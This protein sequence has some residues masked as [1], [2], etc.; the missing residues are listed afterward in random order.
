M[1]NLTSVGF[2]GKLPRTGD[3]VQRRLPP[4]FVDKWDG[5]FEAAVAGVRV[6]LAQEWPA[7]YRESPIWRFVLAPG[8]CT[9]SGWAGVFGPSVDRVGRWF[10]M[11][12]AAPLNADPAAAVRLLRSGDNWFNE[13]E[14]AYW[15]G[16]SSE[17]SSLEVFDARV[18]ALSG[19]LDHI[20]HNVSVNPKEVDW[21]AGTH[22][23][24]PIPVAGAVSVWMSDVWSQLLLAQ[25]PWCQWWTIGGSKRV[26][27]TTLLTQGLPQSSAY[28]GFLK[29]DC[30]SSVWQ[31]PPGIVFPDPFLAA[32]SRPLTAFASTGSCVDG[33]GLS[34]PEWADRVA[35]EGDWSTKQPS[36]GHLGAL[37]SGLTCGASADPDLI[38]LAACQPEE[39]RHV[40]VFHK[41]SL[42]LILVAADDGEILGDRHGTDQVGAI[43]EALSGTS[44]LEAA[45]LRKD[46][47]DLHASLAGSRDDLI[48]PV[49]EDTAVLVLKPSGT[50]AEW[51]RFGAA[52]IWRWRA[53]SVSCVSPHV[54]SPTS[55]T[56][57]N[58]LVLNERDYGV[59][60]ADLTGLGGSLPPDYEHGVCDIIN[61]DRFLMGVTRNFLERLSLDLITKALALASCEAASDCIVNALGLHTQLS[62][63]PFAVFEAPL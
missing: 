29:N 27:P 4:Q 22:W 40:L 12:L 5:S 60:R 7:I 41:Q 25:G 59:L 43:V 46:L 20:A 42:G 55:K 1:Q 36:D 16:Q 61:G 8:I 19:P 13:L 53:G 50:N 15:V 14:Q 31:M 34:P 39:T 37:A 24:L 63:R 18:A 54:Y 3:F 57:D 38:S 56:D 48:N 26:T 10:P 30:G 23:R 51:F 17:C 33:L 11:V 35:N 58:F 52:A 47:F 28:L 2:F 6:A 32:Q 21:G 44:R 9:E 62:L 45:A 49:E